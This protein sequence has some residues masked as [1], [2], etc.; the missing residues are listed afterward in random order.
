M[1]III[2]SFINILV[3]H[4]HLTR[5]YIIQKYISVLDS[6]A[7]QALFNYD[8]HNIKLKFISDKNYNTV[9]EQY[10]LIKHFR[11]ILFQNMFIEI[12]LFWKG[13]YQPEPY[14]PK[15]GL[16][17]IDFSQ[18]TIRS[19]TL[20]DQSHFLV[21]LIKNWESYASLIFFVQS[22]INHNLNLL[23]WLS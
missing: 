13:L 6:D 17:F 5:A 10:I 14:H 19:R 18:S 4:K 12:N 22:W 3:I 9:L 1:W 7:Q 11:F 20:R 2:Y 15:Y 21:D 16:L 23:T 8:L